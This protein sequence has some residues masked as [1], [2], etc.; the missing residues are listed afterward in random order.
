MRIIETL[1]LYLTTAGTVL[2]VLAVFLV[3]LLVR[4]AWKHEK[5][6]GDGSKDDTVKTEKKDQRKWAETL[7]SRVFWNSLVLGGGIF[8]FVWWKFY[9]TEVS[10]R[11][12][13]SWSWNYWLHALVLWGIAAI[14]VKLNASDGWATALQKTLVGIVFT[15]LVVLPV[16]SWWA[17][18]PSKAATN[19]DRVEVPFVQGPKSSWP[20]PSWPT[21]TLEKE[22]EKKHFSFLPW[23]RPVF[24]G[25]EIRVHCGYRDGHTVSF[26]KDEEPCPEG[27]MV[28]VDVENLAKGVNTVYYA[29]KRV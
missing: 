22:G 8:A 12:V 6:K 16:W 26:G 17:S 1:E 20:E 15:F 29:F 13:G 19:G 3:V 25:K 21:L 2:A 14:L 7:A 10:P 11:D 28:S 5:K 18:S 24:Y 4:N 23:Q 27:D 9:G